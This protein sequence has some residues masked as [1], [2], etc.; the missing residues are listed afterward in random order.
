MASVDEKRR[1]GRARTYRKRVPASAAG[2]PGAKALSA[3]PLSTANLRA[4]A[5]TLVTRLLELEWASEIAAPLL[6]GVASGLG[7]VTP[8][9]ELYALV[10]RDA[11]MH[12]L[13]PARALQ[14]QLGALLLIAPFT[15]VSLWLL[16]ANGRLRCLEHLG[17][18][19]PS[20]RI[21]QAAFDAL[22]GIPPRTVG[23][24]VRIHAVPVTVHGQTR[25]ALVV[26]SAAG[27]EP[28]IAYAEEGAQALA[29]TLGR[30]ILLDRLAAQQG[31]LEAAERR[32][33]RVGLDLH[34]GPLQRVSL[35]MGEIADMRRRLRVYE[36][37]LRDQEQVARSLDDQLRRLIRAL[38]PTSVRRE[39]DVVLKR[40]IR[41]STRDSDLAVRVS[42]R[43]AAWPTTQ[44]QRIALA[45]VVQEALANVREHSHATS[46][47][48]SLTYGRSAVTLRVADNGRG[49]DPSA[50]AGKARADRLG[51][52][53]MAERIQLLDGVFEIESQ[54][55]GPTVVSVV[56]PR[57]ELPLDRGELE[58]LGSEIQP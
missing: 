15:D 54:P 26:R 35:L 11:R 51:L 19:T 53:A 6:S 57:F 32:V 46:A 34:D 55:G 10:A 1:N 47:E 22:E 43:G 58:S 20:R 37:Q 28:S 4:V 52:S 8:S 33:T 56:L 5:S 25:A 49:F 18:R 12:E 2:R 48:V 30:Q 17:A 24:R 44:S 3:A 21:R 29:P 41:A 27:Q 13:A 31:L 45:R 14:A 40:Q 38:P 36:E 16:L 9:P 42:V 39:L 50:R 23:Q 7:D